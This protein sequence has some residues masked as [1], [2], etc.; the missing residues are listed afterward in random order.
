MAIWNGPEPVIV[1]SMT[2]AWKW[3]C[4]ETGRNG[5]A[6]NTTLI[7]PTNPS[8]KMQGADGY[9]ETRTFTEY[10]DPSDSELMSWAEQNMQEYL[11]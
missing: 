9:Y 1:D 7:I 8:L 10:P 5:N 4:S 3:T 2:V 6:C 11:F